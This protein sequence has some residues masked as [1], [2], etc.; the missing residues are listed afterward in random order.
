MTAKTWEHYKN[1]VYAIAQSYCTYPT[2]KAAPCGDK[3][4]I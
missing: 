1:V 3:N 4:E 2:I